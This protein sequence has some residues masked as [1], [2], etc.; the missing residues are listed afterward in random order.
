MKLNATVIL[1]LICG[2]SFVYGQKI[3]RSSLNAFGNVAQSDGI[4]LSQTAGQ[5]SNHSILNSNNGTFELRQG[6]QQVNSNV[7]P[8]RS[9]GLQFTVYP[10]PN[11]GNFSIT[12]DERIEGELNYRLIDNQGRLYK[13]DKII[14]NGIN[15]FNFN[16]PSG[17]YILQL[18]DPEGKSGI[19]KIIILP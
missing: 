10:N 9:K 15:H 16:L 3:V 14:A 11:K 1:L 5:S 12:F 18:I 17:S 7:V 4:K 13:V 2:N 8:V 6:F 19:A